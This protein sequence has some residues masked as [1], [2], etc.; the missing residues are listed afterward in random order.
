MIY[1]F[2]KVNKFHQ[3]AA[4]EETL[5]NGSNTRETLEGKYN[6]KDSQGQEVK[7]KVSSSICFPIV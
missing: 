5:V 1:S 6:I 3:K 7:K 2:V 4:A